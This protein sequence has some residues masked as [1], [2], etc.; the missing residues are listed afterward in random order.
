MKWAISRRAQQLTSSA[1]RE[2]LKVTERPEVISFAG[3]LPS[4]ASFPVAAMEAATARVFAD[5]PQ[6]ALQYAATEGYLPLREFV[7]RR[8]GAP[9]ERV[10]ITTGSQQAL[11]LIAKVMIDPGSKVLVETPS[12]LGALQAF[13]L[14]EPEFVSIPSDDKGLLP[15]ALTPELTAGARFLYALP[16]FQNPTGRRLP[17]ERRE[18]LVARA[19]EQGV[20][21]V[22]DDPY[23]ALSYTG[24]QL[25][26]LLSMNP[27][28]VIYMGSF[29]KILAPGMRLGYVI[30][31]PELHFKLCQAKQASDLHTPTFTQRVAYE[32]IRD[33]LLDT[34][35]PTIRE[36]YGK[37]CQY[38]LDALK[39]H[40]PEGVTW[41]A[42]EGGMFI[43]MELPEGLDSMVIL[44]EA[45]KRN[46]AYVPGAPFYASN[47]KRNALRLAFVTVSAE[48]IEQGVAI[49]GELFREAIAAAA[50]KQPRA[51]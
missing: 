11:D 8:H 14:F 20:L 4:P 50:A 17:L 9:V 25:P 29:S 33:G 48:R 23:G 45:V 51:A 38:M 10:L 43:W 12:Y 28:G 49:L 19:K 42:P 31:P 30:A 15:E 18:A 41:N 32:T 34:H 47:P 46:V 37:Q 44:E 2:I 22:E 35:I 6:A 21:L 3:G 16:N 1:I 13:S 27:D 36:L 40:M 24:D 26:S 5:N 7:A 39:R